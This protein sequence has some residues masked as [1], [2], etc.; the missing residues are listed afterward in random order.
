MASLHHFTYVTKVFFYNAIGSL[1]HQV[2]GV[3]LQ[4][5]KAVQSSQLFH[6]QGQSLS[7]PQLLCS[8]ECYVEDP[9]AAAATK[10]GADIFLTMKMLLMASSMTRMTLGSLTCSRLMIASKAP[11]C[12]RVTTCSTVPPLVKLVTAHTASL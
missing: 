4:R 6:Q 12:T 2:I 3:V 10:Q 9:S 5:L 11:L 1:V 7:L 8:L